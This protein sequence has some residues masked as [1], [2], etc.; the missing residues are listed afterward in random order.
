M[1]A[2]APEMPAVAPAGKLPPLLT[3]PQLPPRPPTPPDEGRNQWQSEEIRG[4]QRQSVAIR[5]YQTPC[6]PAPP[7][8]G[9]NQRQSEAIRGNQRLLDDAPTGSGS[10]A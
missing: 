9:R 10:G 5:D 1:P 7:D 4:C 3:P 8:E 6:P 2:T